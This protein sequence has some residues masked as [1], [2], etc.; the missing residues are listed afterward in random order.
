MKALKGYRTILFN[1]V[2]LIAGIMGEELAPETA[3]DLVEAF[4]VVWA[5]GNAFLRWITDSPIGE[6]I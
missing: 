6:K 1:I 3:N 2:M 5:A 4:L